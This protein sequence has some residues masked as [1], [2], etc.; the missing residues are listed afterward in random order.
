MSGREWGLG[1]GGG[2]VKQVKGGERGRGQVAGASRRTLGRVGGG[3]Q[4]RGEEWGESTL[5]R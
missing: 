5:S 4:G 1:R 2:V 3:L